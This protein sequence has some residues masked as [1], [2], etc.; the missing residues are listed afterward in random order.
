MAGCSAS[1]YLLG[2]TPLELPAFMAGTVA[3]MTVWGVVYASLGGASRSL[4]KSGMDTEQLFGGQ[5]PHYTAPF[6]IVL[7]WIALHR[8]VLL[9]MRSRRLQCQY[10]CI[11]LLHVD[12]NVPLQGK[13]GVCD[14]SWTAACRVVALQSSLLLLHGWCVCN[15]PHKIHVIMQPFVCLACCVIVSVL[16]AILQFVTDVIQWTQGLLAPRLHHVSEPYIVL[17]V[18]R[19]CFKGQ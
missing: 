2:M 9:L 11:Y 6:C 13:I 1:N 3:G 15:S 10:A 4:L 19:S 5:S 12:Y 16:R 14:L 8:T 7:D 17:G 18:Y